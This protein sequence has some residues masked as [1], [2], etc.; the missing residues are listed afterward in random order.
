MVENIKPES[1]WKRNSFKK[2][3]KYLCDC[4]S[5][6]STSSET[7]SSGTPILK[8]IYL[9]I[10]DTNHEITIVDSNLFFNIKDQDI[11]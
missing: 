3:T 1:I 11:D 8:G 6:F 9:P 10:T 7:L 2:L 4:T 5:L